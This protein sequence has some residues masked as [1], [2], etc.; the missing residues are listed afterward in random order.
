MDFEQNDIFIS[1]TDG[2]H[3]YR[4]PSLLVTKS[5]TLL[6]FCE[7]RVHSTGDHGAIHLLVKRSE[8]NGRTWSGQSIIWEDGENTCGNPCAV[9]DSSTGTI[10]LAMNWNRPSADS[11][12]FFHSCDGRYVY[13][14]ASN[15]DGLT[16]CKPRDITAEVKLRTWGWHA[17]GPGVGIELKTGANAGRMLIPCNHSEAAGADD[18]CGSSVFYSDDHGES[19]R[20]GGYTASDGLDECQIVELNDG[21]IMLNARTSKQCIPYR[22][23]SISN[24]GGMTWSSVQA[25]Q[26]L[27]DLNC[28]G[29][30][31]HTPEGYLV[32]TNPVGE[33]RTG[34]TIR[35]STDNG[36]TWPVSL[37]LYEGHSA[38]SSLTM[39]PDGRIACLYERG[40]QHPYENL[41]FA[42]FDIEWLQG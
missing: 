28:Q 12:D 29:S 2:Y 41:T 7:G 15:D 32:F 35:V 9:Q 10:W 18:C 23:I 36:A 4:I 33:N 1:G 30:I 21:R 17:T 19:W 14:T 6:A 24:D 42:A 40:L 26:Q 22:R 31:I 25:D 13:M 11:Y 37:C 39:L 34:L 5:G 16:W 3:T 38:Y 27:P 8:D 20:L